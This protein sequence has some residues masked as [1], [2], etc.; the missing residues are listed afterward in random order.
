[1]SNYRNKNKTK[2]IYI[3]KAEAETYGK[4][5]TYRGQYGMTAQEFLMWKAYQAYQAAKKV[6]T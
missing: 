3:R 1:M 2:S 4:A 6:T 5:Y